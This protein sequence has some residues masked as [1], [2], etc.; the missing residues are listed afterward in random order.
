MTSWGVG[1]VFK[2]IKI[3]STHTCLLQCTTS[4]KSS[5]SSLIVLRVHGG[6]EESWKFSPNTFLMPIIITLASSANKL[7]GFFILQ[8]L[9]LHRRKHISYQ[10]I[11]YKLLGST[12]RELKLP[13]DF[14]YI[15]IDE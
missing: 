2:E 4:T 6:R 12:E 9:S 10:N 13:I 15:I 7:G 1:L 5:S 11:L 8:L 3:V 14:Y